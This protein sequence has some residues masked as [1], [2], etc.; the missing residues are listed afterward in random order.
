MKAAR[1]VTMGIPIGSRFIVGTGVF[2]GG[3]EKGNEG[4]GSHLR[5]LKES[6]NK[7]VNPSDCSSKK[8]SHGVI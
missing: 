4:D 2:A 1:D 5:T 6:S 7:S 3:N 8:V